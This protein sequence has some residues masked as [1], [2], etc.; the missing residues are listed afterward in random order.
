MSGFQVLIDLIPIARKPQIAVIV[1]AALLHSE[2]L[3]LP[4]LN[5]APASFV[6]N[7][8]SGDILDNAILKAVAV[9]GLL[10]KEERL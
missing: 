10:R 1:L 9:V 5:G 4:K 7:R 2:L 8:T 6:K 3:E